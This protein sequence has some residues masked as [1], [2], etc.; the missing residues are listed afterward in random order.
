[1]R[2]RDLNGVPVLPRARPSRS[3]ARSA[4]SRW[5]LRGR[6]GVAVNGVDHLVRTVR[7]CG[8]EPGTGHQAPDR[9]VDRRWADVGD[10]AQRA[11]LRAPR[12]GAVAVERF[13]F[14]DPPAQHGAPHPPAADREHADV[15]LVLSRSGAVGEGVMTATAIGWATASARCSARGWSSS[16]ASMPSV[17]RL[18]S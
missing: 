1:M 5:L 8:G 4:P 7:H 15:L 13:A 17:D 9:R 6:L 16:W 2:H 10:A 3:S 11:R 12:A 14:M 18:P